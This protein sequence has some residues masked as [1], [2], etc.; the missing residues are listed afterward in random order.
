LYVEIEKIELNKL[1]E[2]LKQQILFEKETL[3]LF[4]KPKRLI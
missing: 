1:K 4:K 3:N 2:E